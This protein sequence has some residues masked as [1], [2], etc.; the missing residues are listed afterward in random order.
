MGIA[1]IISGILLYEFTSLLYILDGLTEQ[2][3]LLLILGFALII[4]GFAT[5]FWPK[6]TIRLLKAF[7]E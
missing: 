4:F 2:S 1:Y 3:I 5:Y 6:Q 7:A